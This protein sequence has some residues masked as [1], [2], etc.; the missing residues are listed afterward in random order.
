MLYRRSL[1]RASRSRA[2]ARRSASLVPT[3]L[4]TAASAI[5]LASML[6]AAPALAATDGDENARASARAEDAGMENAAPPGPRSVGLMF[7]LGTLDG[8]M[9]S[10]VYRPASWLR[11]HAGGGTNGASPGVRAGAAIP[12]ARGWGISL[13]GGHFFPGDLNGLFSA[14][15]GPD[16]DDSHLLERFDYDFA[17]LQLGWEIERSDL[18]FFVR[19]GVGYVWSQLPQEGL[20]RVENLSSLVD[21]DGS[22]EV[23]LPSLKLGFIGFL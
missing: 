16:Y 15:A 2:H 13:E 6:A 19:A 12:I 9:M 23:L 4:E 10:L 11:L 5:A 20:T 8:G 18:V 22:V 14:F 7:D 21:P 17:N 3:A 1:P